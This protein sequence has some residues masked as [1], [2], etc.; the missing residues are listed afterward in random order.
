MQAYLCFLEEKET[1]LNLQ[2][3]IA[4]VTQNAAIAALS[5]TALI[6][7]APNVLLFLFPHFASGEGRSSKFLSLGQAL[8]AGGLLG[9]VFLHVVPHS[10][11][12]HDVGLWIL[13]GFSLF[14]LTDMLLRSMGGNSHGHHHHDKTKSPESKTSTVLLNLTADSLHNFTDGLAIGTSF[15]NFTGNVGN[16][17]VLNLVQSRG[18]LATLS[19]LFH[20]IPH[21]LGDFAILVKSGFSKRE[22]IFAQFG[23]AVS[24]ML[25]CVVGLE[26]ADL[27]GDSLI[28]ITSGGFVYL[29]TVNILPDILDE[30]ASLRFRLTQLLFFSFGVAFLYA[31]C[32]LEEMSGEHGHSHGHHDHHDEARHLHEDHG[33]GHDHGHHHGHG[34]GHGHDHNHHHFV[35]L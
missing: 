7:L 31:V 17:S 26:A 34:H 11:G 13:L 3:T 20:E 6:S 4:M 32:L 23:T 35:E 21:E 19:I 25:G 9:D 2:T 8:A 33:H 12:S 30:T 14:L 27:A 1:K 5:S 16:G 10:G 22:A 15:A 28:F 18:G 24:A 29:A